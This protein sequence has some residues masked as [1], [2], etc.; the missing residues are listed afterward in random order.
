M[1]ME[2][3]S[4][5]SWTSEGVWTILGK[6]A[7]SVGGIIFDEHERPLTSEELAG[8]RQE[9]AAARLQEEHLRAQIDFYKSH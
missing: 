3:P 1:S 4:S 9:Q 7:A 6:V 8:I 2:L 5:R